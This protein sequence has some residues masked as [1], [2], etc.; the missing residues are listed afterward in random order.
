MVAREELLTVATQ[1][2]PRDPDF[3]ER[4]S[5]IYHF[6][7]RF[8]KAIEEAR[9]AVSLGSSRAWYIWGASLAAN[10]DLMGAKGVFETS[11]SNVG[12][13]YSSMRGLVFSGLYSNDP[14][15]VAYGLNGLKNSGF[16][17]ELHATEFELA[18]FHGEIAK[19]RVIYKD[20][21]ERLNKEGR[22]QLASLVSSRW[23]LSLAVLGFCDEAM[24]IGR[25]LTSR[26]NISS[27]YSTTGS[28]FA[29]CGDPAGSD[30]LLQ[31]Q[32]D[33]LPQGTIA[34]RLV[35]PQIQA[36]NL[37]VAG[38]YGDAITELSSVPRELEPRSS[39]M[40][41]FIR[42]NS[43]LRTKQFE[44]AASEFRRIIEYP[45][46]N[47]NMSVFERFPLAYLGLGRANAA[48]DMADDARTAYEKFFEIW[49]NADPD[50]EELKKA[51]QEYAELQNK[52][53]WN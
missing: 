29:L 25:D 38:R 10:G 51:R 31:M 21:S 32:L 14:Q 18:I 36:L 49:K 50:I 16:I 43:L 24:E 5:S 52:Y 33:R 28:L 6:V 27:L 23:A 45:G 40:V 34:N 48:M 22:Q 13:H 44:S 12:T 11:F 1:V 7:G 47:A 37:F 19:G 20:L 53:G 4:L 26:E 17:N 35:A 39:S 46:R 41:T 30:R 2:F 9:R 42:A 15:L 3:S 8:D